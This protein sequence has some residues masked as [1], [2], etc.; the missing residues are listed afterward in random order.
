LIP[1]S[2]VAIGTGNA[3]VQPGDTALGGEVFRKAIKAVDPSQDITTTDQNKRKVILTAE[4]DFTEGNAALT[5]AGCSTRLRG[6]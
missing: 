5:E 2:H 4:L 6:E 1:V 3:A